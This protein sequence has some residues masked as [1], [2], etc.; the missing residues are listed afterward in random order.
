[1]AYLPRIVNALELPGNSVN[2]EEAI[3]PQ[4]EVFPNPANSTVTSILLNQSLKLRFK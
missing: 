1:M 3:V 2:I 4:I